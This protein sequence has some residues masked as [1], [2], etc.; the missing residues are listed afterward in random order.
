RVAA[1]VNNL[2][3]LGGFGAGCR[4][5]PV[6]KR[7]DGYPAMATAAS[8]VIENESSLAGRINTTCESSKLAIKGDGLAGAR[9]RQALDNG[10]GKLGRHE[11]AVNNR[12]TKKCASV[13]PL[14]SLFVK[15]CPLICKTFLQVSLFSQG[16][17]C[18]CK[19]LAKRPN[20]N[21]KSLG[22]FP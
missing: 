19:D 8:P 4:R 18:R 16:F 2:L 3:E 21:L 20:K 12:S 9:Y 17:V 5:V 13:V 11:S 10:V 7:A 1:T 6:W 15:Q 22:R 14:L